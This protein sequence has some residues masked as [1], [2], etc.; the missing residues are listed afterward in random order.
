MPID[1]A[2][3]VTFVPRRTTL[4]FPIG[5]TKSSSL[6][7]G[8]DVPYKISFSRNITGLGSRI[9][10]FKRPLASAAEYGATTLR[11]GTC[12]YQEVKSWLCC[13]PTLAAAPLGPRNTIGQPIWPPDI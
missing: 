9:A 1:Q 12:E 6:G 8:W 13:A 7:T 10:A 3:M 5:K 2:T 11:P 4:A